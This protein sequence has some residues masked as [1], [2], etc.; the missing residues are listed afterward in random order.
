[1]LCA[2][3]LIILHKPINQQNIYRTLKKNNQSKNKLNKQIK[4]YKTLRMIKKKKFKSISVEKISNI[5]FGEAIN[6][7]LIR[8]SKF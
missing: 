6:D 1:M 5:G 4:N 3:M 8:A 7:R 2:N